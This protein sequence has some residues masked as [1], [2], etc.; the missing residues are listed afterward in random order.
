MH[1]WFAFYWPILAQKAPLTETKEPYIRRVWGSQQPSGWPLSSLW[2]L[3]GLSCI[4]HLVTSPSRACD[5]FLLESGNDRAIKHAFP[6]GI[7]ESGKGAEGTKT[8][9]ARLFPSAKPEFGRTER[10]R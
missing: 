4:V 8:G 2:S 7:S 1:R 6:T 10:T 3:S 5:I 9:L